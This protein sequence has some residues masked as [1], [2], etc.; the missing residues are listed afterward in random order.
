[1]IYISVRVNS[2][3]FELKQYVY[4]LHI[5]QK[6]HS[7]TKKTWTLTRLT[8]TAYKRS[9]F[10]WLNIMDVITRR[11]D[12]LHVTEI[13][14]QLGQPLKNAKSCRNCLLQLLSKDVWIQMQLAFSDG[15][16]SIFNYH[17][18]FRNNQLKWRNKWMRQNICFIVSTC[19]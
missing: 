8:C 3:K 7:S 15:T 12:R 10:K 2:L 4:K 5:I 19:L 18:S 17:L 11:L 9:M 14:K 16:N 1:M 6:Y 13:Q